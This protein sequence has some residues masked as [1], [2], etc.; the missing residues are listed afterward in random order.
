MHGYVV[1]VDPGAWITPGRLTEL[2]DYAA[3]YDS[4]AGAK[5]ALTWF[6][7]KR[8]RDFPEAQIYPVRV[9]VER[10]AS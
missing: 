4:E 3:V 5:C 9:R 2:I 7:K 1:E 10:V 8:Q 6:S